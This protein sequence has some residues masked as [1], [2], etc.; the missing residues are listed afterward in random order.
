MFVPIVQNSIAGYYQRY[1]L[2]SFQEKIILMTLCT[3][4]TNMSLIALRTTNSNMSPRLIVLCTDFTNMSPIEL[5]LY[6]SFM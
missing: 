3:D 2:C 4:V 6:A 1:D 5:C